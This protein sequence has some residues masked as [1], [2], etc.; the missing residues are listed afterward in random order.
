M[1]FDLQISQVVFIPRA[2]PHAQSLFFRTGQDLIT[3]LGFSI[4]RRAARAIRESRNKDGEIFLA[5]E[6]MN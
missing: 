2:Q 5:K 4:T 1:L 6:S 3:C